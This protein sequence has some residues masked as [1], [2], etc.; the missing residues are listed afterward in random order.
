MIQRSKLRRL[1]EDDGYVEDEEEWGGA[2]W[3]GKEVPVCGALD[4]EVPATRCVVVCVAV[5]VAVY[6]AVCVAV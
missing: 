3:V 1:E 6:V 4:T 5:R 2:R